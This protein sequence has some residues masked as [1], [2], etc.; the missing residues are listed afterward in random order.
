MVKN[1]SW[2]VQHLEAVKRANFER[3]EVS[4]TMVMGTS[5]CHD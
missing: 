3:M 4:L 1:V 2:S 5:I